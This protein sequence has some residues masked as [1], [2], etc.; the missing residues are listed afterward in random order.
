MV[1]EEIPVGKFGF[2]KRQ[3]LDWL[4]G[5][6]S[7]VVTVIV[8]IGILLFGASRFM[9]WFRGDAQIDFVAAEV[10]YNKWHG[11]K[12]ALPKLEKLIQ[13]HPELHAKYDGAIAQKLLHSSEHG[14]ASSYAS[15]V[16]KRVES[17]SPYYTQFANATVMIAQ[18]R[19]AD[20]L[21]RAKEL[22]QSMENDDRFWEKRSRVVKHGSL[23]YG[24]NLLRI[25]IL[26]KTAGSAEGELLAWRALK[27]NAGWQGGSPASKTYDP[28][29]Y[30][31]IQQNFQKQDI[32][33]L[34][35][36]NHRESKIMS[37]E[38]SP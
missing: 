20:A 21:V 11:E 27:Q 26:E 7:V 38:K 18:G 14:L 8:G 13:R 10:A 35:Y 17:F 37:S 28:E 22:K 36:I 25:A 1:I 34:D 3:T 24:Y 9:G 31:L 29:A 2:I 5:H 30:G 32:S 15:Q 19:L 16:L 33:L 12:E 4:A 23:L 6:M